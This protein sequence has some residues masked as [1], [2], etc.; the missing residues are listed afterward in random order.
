MYLRDIAKFGFDV[1]GKRPKHIVTCCTWKIF[2]NDNI[3]W[4]KE[5]TIADPKETTFVAWF[6]LNEIY[7]DARNLKYHEITENYV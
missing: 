3:W 7:P 1:Y 2:T 4:I 6:K 5:E